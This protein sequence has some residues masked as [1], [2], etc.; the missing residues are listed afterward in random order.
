MLL[1]MAIFITDFGVL[2]DIKRLGWMLG[3]FF[4]IPLLFVKRTKWVFFRFSFAQLP[5][6]KAVVFF[7][8]LLLILIWLVFECRAA[9]SQVNHAATYHELALHLK[10]V[11]LP[12]LMIAVYL[13]LSYAGLMIANLVTPRKLSSSKTI[14]R[15]L[16]GANVLLLVAF[17]FDFGQFNSETHFSIEPLENGIKQQNHSVN[18][19]KTLIAVVPN[20]DELMELMAIAASGE[21]FLQLHYFFANPK[22]PEWRQMAAFRNQ[23]FDANAAVYEIGLEKMTNFCWLLLLDIT[24]PDLATENPQFIR[25]SITNCIDD[26]L[27]LPPTVFFGRLMSDDHYLAQSSKRDAL[28]LRQLPNIKFFLTEPS[29]DPS[30]IFIEP[31]GAIG[32]LD[33]VW[34]QEN[35]IRRL[36]ENRKNRHCEALLGECCKY[37][38]F[39]ASLQCDR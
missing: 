19:G 23:S 38:F 4:L 8:I 11:K 14:R 35:V 25:R 26:A 28:Y 13:V 37:R 18:T 7:G 12:L 17:P 31:V 20:A 21:S 34:H 9:V 33:N 39:F 2:T 10:G 24:S 36:D 22:D 3:C 27:T 30:A 1:V 15:A 16:I 5:F 29:K 32:S 6:H